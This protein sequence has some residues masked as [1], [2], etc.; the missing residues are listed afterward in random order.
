MSPR[1]SHMRIPGRTIAIVLGASLL[2]GCADLVP[3]LRDDYMGKSLLQP[4]TVPKQIK[5]DDDGNPIAEDS[6]WSFPRLFPWVFN[7]N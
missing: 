3:T 5:N 2:L 6:G 7:T 1:S 4:Y